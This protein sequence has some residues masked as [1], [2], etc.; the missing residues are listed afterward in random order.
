MNQINRF[1]LKE[2]QE[3]VLESS[4]FIFLSIRTTAK[5][6]IKDFRVTDHIN[7]I[8]VDCNLD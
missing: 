6:I 4:L 5:F 7:R 8:N 2:S 1:S 3:V